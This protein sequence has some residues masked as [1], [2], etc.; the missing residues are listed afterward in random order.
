MRRVGLCYGGR[1]RCPKKTL[2]NVET[3]EV[4]SDRRFEIKLFY[5]QY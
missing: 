1:V 5:L 4:K 2:L 3:I